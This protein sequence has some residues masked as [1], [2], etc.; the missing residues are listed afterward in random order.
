V[1]AA[2]EPLALAIHLFQENLRYDK[3]AEALGGHGEYVTARPSS[4]RRSNAPTP[5]PPR[6]ANPR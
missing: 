3:V 5:L 1:Q 4:A 2:R 6:N